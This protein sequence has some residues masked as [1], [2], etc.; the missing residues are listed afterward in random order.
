MHRRDLLRLIPLTAAGI[1]GSVNAIMAQEAADRPASG[2]KP[3]S[4]ALRYLR[5]SREK[6][7]WVHETQMA[8]LL[9]GAYAIAATV[10][11]G[12]HCWSNW[13]MGHN[14]GFDLFSDRNG[15]PEMFTVGYNAEKAVKGDLLLV[16]AYSGSMEDVLGKGVFV[17]GGPDPYSL[18]GHGEEPFR[19][20][21][22]NR[23]FR[24]Y[25]N[26]WIDNG[27][28]RSDGALEIPG[29]IVKICPVSP[30]LGMT[31]FWMMV[32]DACR[33]LARDGA[34]VKVKGDE[35]PLSGEAV[36][37]WEI[38][39]RV[40]L[41]QPLME[42]YFRHLM[43]QQNA[44]EAEMGRIR[45][46]A[47]M[48]VDTVLSGGISY[49]YSRSRN[50]LAVE[51]NTRRSGLAI[52]NGLADGGEEKDLHFVNT[53]VPS[54][55]LSKKDC[56]VM[57]FTRPDDPVDLD[58]LGKFRKAGMKIISIGP[59]T[60]DFKVPAGR[61]VPKE[62]D[63]H[64]GRMCDTYGLFAIPGFERKVCPTSGAMINQIFWALNAEIVEQ[65]IVRSG[66]DVPGAFANVAF[67]DGRQ[68]MHHM[69]ELY[70]E[71]GY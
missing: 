5:A 30:V 60:R 35:P 2:D 9:E 10:K 11:R 34:A 14:I 19:S 1:A 61:T 38:N 12:G 29:S 8:Y 20:D 52:F 25:A 6:L 69:L 21:L 44:I 36:Q 66:G 47:A 17:I 15:E 45:K 28:T 39:A 42:H 57:G 41:D 32:A 70:K 27:M 53:L 37:S 50:H 46:A 58:N 68:I 49:C 40:S 51:G 31:T 55:P 26:L 54:R 7:Q 13:N 56:V 18:D 71:R 33:I 67:E 64:I 22:V 4:L 65:F 63:I 59:L 23:R 48:V 3:E 24:Q 62:A 16:S 43:E